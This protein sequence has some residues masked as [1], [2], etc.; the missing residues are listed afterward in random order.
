MQRTPPST[1]GRKRGEQR[2]RE[3]YVR[4]QRVEKERGGA[5]QGEE[6]RTWLRGPEE[7]GRGDEGERGGKRDGTKKYGRRETPHPVHFSYSCVKANK[8]GRDT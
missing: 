6:V 5:R 3:G 7:R 1:G 4:A 2:E 8:R